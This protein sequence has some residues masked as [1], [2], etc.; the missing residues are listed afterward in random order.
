MIIQ[1]AAVV[2]VFGD[3]RSVSILTLMTLLFQLCLIFMASQPQAPPTRYTSCPRV[4]SA[5]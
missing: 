5:L 1:S 4:L 2:I 3:T